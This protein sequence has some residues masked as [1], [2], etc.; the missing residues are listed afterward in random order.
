MF[1]GFISDQPPPTDHQ[2]SGLKHPYPQFDRAQIR[3]FRAPPSSVPIMFRKRL[4]AGG[5]GAYGSLSPILLS[6]L[7]GIFR[8]SLFVKSPNVHGSPSSPTDCSAMLLN[9]AFTS[10]SLSFLHLSLAKTTSGRK[11]TR[12][13]D[14]YAG[15]QPILDSR[16]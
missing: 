2:F 4:P 5:S 15:L 16:T 12:F 3:Q 9:L 1:E 11:R 6:H 8:E 13:T 14:S 7:C 10:F